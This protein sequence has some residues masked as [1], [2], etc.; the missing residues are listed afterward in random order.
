MNAHALKSGIIL[1]VITIVIS[2]LVYLVDYTIFANWWYQLLLMNAIIIGVTAYFGISYRNSDEGYLSFGKS[3]VYSIICFLTSTFIGT[4]FAILL[5]NVIDTDL[6]GN[7]TDAI[8]DKTE[9]MMSG[10]GAP[11]DSIDEQVE[12]LREEMPAN[13]TIG[14]MIK[15]FF[16]SSLLMIA[17]ISLISSLFIKKKEPD[18]ED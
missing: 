7:L 5:Y 16:T 10:F 13:F 4:I 11:Q 8:V 18:F 9:S 3:Y 14:G 6:S 12:K 15:N 1:G 17:I 2:L